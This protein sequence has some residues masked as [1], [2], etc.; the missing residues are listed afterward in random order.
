M[1]SAF[2]E[3]PA[4]VVDPPFPVSV[5]DVT[6]ADSVSFVGSPPLVA[7]AEASGFPLDEPPSPEPVS[8][9][10]SPDVE[11]MPSLVDMVSEVS[12]DVGEASDALAL[13]AWLASSVAL[14]GSAPVVALS[15]PDP[16]PVSEADSVSVSASSLR[17]CTFTLPSPPVDVALLSAVSV[18]S[19]P[20][21]ALVSSPLVFVVPAVALSEAVEPSE[22]SASEEEL[23]E[24]GAE[25]A[26]KEVSATDVVPSE[27]GSAE[28]ASPEVSAVEV[29]SSEAVV[30]VTS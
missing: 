14:E 10:P 30:E 8:S 13:S 12:S 2:G 6:G 22:V 26:S 3:D 20:L 11:G 9:G 24:G 16:D 29:E 1:D 7:V 19:A 23:L 4:S 15:D 5:S 17:A 27:V 21:V 28:V 18:E 25:V